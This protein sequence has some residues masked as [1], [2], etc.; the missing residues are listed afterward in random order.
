MNDERHTCEEMG[1]RIPG[2]RRGWGCH[3]D[4]PQEGE[5]GRAWRVVR[6]CSLL[7]QHN[8]N[9]IQHYNESTLLLLGTVMPC[10]SQK[11]HIIVRKVNRTW[12]V[13]ERLV[14]VKEWGEDAVVLLT[15]TAN[16]DFIKIWEDIEKV[17]DE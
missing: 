15:I 12:K 16:R 8:S 14:G 10:Q 6:A 7:V 3:L 11:I 2:V 13:E 1:E 4:I 9:I 5:V 17:E